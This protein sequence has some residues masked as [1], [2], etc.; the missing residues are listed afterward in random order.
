MGIGVIVIWSVAAPAAVAGAA[1]L[2]CARGAGGIR[3]GVSCAGVAA[4]A[5]IAAV[6]TLGW[7]RTG[8]GWR[9]VGVSDRLTLAVMVL[10]CAAVAAVWLWGKRRRGG[11]VVG[12]AVVVAVMTGCHWM[13]V[14][15]L[16]G[17]D[18]VSRWMWVGGLALG[19][20]V[21]WAL[22]ARTIGEDANA[23]GRRWSLACVGVVA[24][25]SASVVVLWGH[26]KMGPLCGAIGVGVL[27]VMAVEWLTGRRCAPGSAP[28]YVLFGGLALWCVWGT[29]YL[30]RESQAPWWSGLMLAASPLGVWAG[31]MPVVRRWRWWARGPVMLGVCAGLAGGALVV[32]VGATDVSVY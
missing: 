32:A 12:A 23:W 30:F 31:A 11:V 18:A 15:A 24:V 14:S 16:T 19:G 9:V 2:L 26:L 29:A 3:R 1:T 21:V 20:M 25:V 4:G 10:T 27:A 6:G 22:V 5:V 17:F 7:P 28:E 13:T 8:D